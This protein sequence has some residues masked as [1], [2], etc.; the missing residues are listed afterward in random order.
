MR[1]TRAETS[2]S[3]DETA[4]RRQNVATGVS[5]WISYLGRTKR[6]SG[7]QKCFA[8]LRNN[9][10]SPLTG[11]TFHFRRL[12]RAYARGYQLPPFRGWLE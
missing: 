3:N 11:L 10:L 9:L 5:P 7:R 12:P 2:D 8:I 6:A 1:S 4:E